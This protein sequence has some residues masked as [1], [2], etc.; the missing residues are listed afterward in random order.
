MRASSFVLLVLGDFRLRR[1]PH[2]V[3][4]AALVQALGLQDDVQ[5]LV[6]R[7]VD[8]AQRDVALHGVGRDDVEVGFL[9]DQLQ[10]RA[11]RNVLEVERHRACRCRRAR[12]RWMTTAPV[13]VAAPAAVGAR[14]ARRRAA[15]SRPRSRAGLVG[16][17]F[18][19]PV[20]AEHELACRRRWRWRRCA[21]PGVAKSVTSMGF[22]SEAGSCA[23]PTSTTTLE[24]AVAQV[25]RGAVTVEVQD[26]A[27]RAAVAA[28]EVDVGDGDGAGHA[29]WPDR[30]CRLARA[31][32]AS[33]QRHQ[34]RRTARRRRRRT[35]ASSPAASADQRSPALG[36]GR[37]AGRRLLA[38]STVIVL[39]PNH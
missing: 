1:D 36:M 22:C 4:A 34:A 3:A 5:R 7:H 29:A 38:L 19:R 17:R 27:T 23:L 21:A 37:R 15:R 26:Q 31:C 12:C 16:H 20:G 6:P 18:E 10:H 30:R 25:G 32:A 11:H 35:A 24:P 2:D 13:A 39:F 14:L 9:G 28:L 8:Q 33:R